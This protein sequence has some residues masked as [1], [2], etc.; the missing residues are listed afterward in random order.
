[1]QCWFQQNFYNLQSVNDK[2]MPSSGNQKV[3]HQS[4]FDVDLPVRV[5]PHK[6]MR[7]VK[8]HRV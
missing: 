1:M 6:A 2:F 5:Q 4:R 7:V 3:D 8:N